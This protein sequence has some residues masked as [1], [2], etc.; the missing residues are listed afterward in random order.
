MWQPPT[1]YKRFFDLTKGGNHQPYIIK[2][3]MIGCSG[4]Y[5]R[6]DVLLFTSSIGDL[7]VWYKH[8]WFSWF[9]LDVFLLL[10]SLSICLVCGIFRVQFQNL[11][12]SIV[13]CR[14]VDKINSSIGQDPNSKALIGVLDIYGFESFKFNRLAILFKYHLAYCLVLDLTTAA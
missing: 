3:E 11:T 5:Q 13:N 2:A 10:F 1:L 9:M 6:A 4:P 7:I 12:E 14:L 8:T